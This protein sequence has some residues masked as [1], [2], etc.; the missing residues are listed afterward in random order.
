[1]HTV[2]YGVRDGAEVASV[3]VTQ[4]YDGGVEDVWDALTSAERLPRWFAPVQGDLQRGGRFQ[5]EGNA[6]GTVLECH[7]PRGFTT[8]WEFGGSTSW[9][10]VEVAEAS[11]SRTVVRISHTVPT[12]DDHWRRFGPAAVG[13]GWDLTAAGLRMH[14]AGGGP[15]GADIAAEGVAWMTG[16][17]GVAYLQR[18]GEGWEAAD[19]S[20][21]GDVAAAGERAAASVAVFTTPPS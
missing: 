16:P 21:G 13:L 9:L 12:D 14:L 19:V 20:A 17:E 6:A 8:T 18:C 2:R 15:G 1:M 3:E 11:P 5:I 7:P 10:M 4:T